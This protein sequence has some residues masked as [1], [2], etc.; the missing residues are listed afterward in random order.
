L[1]FKILE[2]MAANGTVKKQVATPWF[3]STYRA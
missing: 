3:E 1:C 2:H